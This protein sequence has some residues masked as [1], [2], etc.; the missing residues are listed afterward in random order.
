[1]TNPLPTLLLLAGIALVISAVI[2]SLDWLQ[3]SAH[4]G[5]LTCARAASTARESWL[6]VASTLLGLAWQDQ[7]RPRQ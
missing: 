5:G 7:R 6:G 2:P 1:M 4:A 3:C